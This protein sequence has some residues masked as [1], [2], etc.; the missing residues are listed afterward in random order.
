MMPASV[1]K[2]RVGSRAPQ[3]RG[4]LYALPAL[5]LL[6]VFAGAP[7]VRAVRLAFYRSNGLGMEEFVLFDNFRRILLDPLFWKSMRVLG[8][9]I[10]LGV[11]LQTIGPLIGAKLLHSLRSA[12]AAFVYRVLFV[13][14]LVIPMVVGVLIWRNL[15]AADG[16]V[17]R[18]LTLVGLEAWQHSWLGDT[19]TVIPAI[20]FMGVPFVGGVNL[21][22][23]LAGFLN[24]P[25]SMYEAAAL[26][27]A[28]P[29]QIFFHIELPWLMPQLRL[30]VVLALIGA[31][32]SYEHIL[33]LTEGG[34][35]NATLVPALYLFKNGFEYGS[36]GYACAVGCILFVITLVLTLINFRLL[37]RRH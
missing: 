31:I 21:L 18:L 10:L 28:T 5:A 23:Y 15:Y 7:F 8:L 9:F 17:N 16:A 12:R 6:A 33:V 19:T 13:L 2:S 25:S 29:R 24:I 4:L 35:A 37:R 30:I 14:P 32:Q 1:E 22:I 27:G 36:L 3:L 20:I 34:P 26:E 11:P